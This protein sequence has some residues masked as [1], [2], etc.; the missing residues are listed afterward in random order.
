MAKLPGQ[1]QPL[2][3]MTLSMEQKAFTAE[4]GGCTRRN[5]FP[6][7]NSQTEGCQYKKKFVVRQKASSEM[8]M[9]EREGGGGGAEVGSREMSSKTNWLEGPH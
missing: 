4:A 1:G 2:P 7:I 5:L 3:F 6:K 8:R 9:R